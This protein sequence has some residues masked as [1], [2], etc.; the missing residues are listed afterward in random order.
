MENKLL[1]FS[2]CFVYHGSE[3]VVDNILLSENI[4]ANFDRCFF[5]GYDYTEKGYLTLFRVNHKRFFNGFRN[6]MLEFKSSFPELFKPKL[7]R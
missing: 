4:K 2:D 5:C 3:S 7:E 6:I 1:I